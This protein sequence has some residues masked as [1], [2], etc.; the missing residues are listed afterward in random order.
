MIFLFRRLCWGIVAIGL[1]FAAPAQ[2]LTSFPALNTQLLGR[3]SFPDSAETYS[4]LAT[5]AADGREYA[6]IGTR[7]GTAFVE[8]TLPDRPRLVAHLPG[9]RPAEWGGR[10]YQTYHHYA[11]GVAD[12]Q[13]GHSLQIFDLQYLPDSVRLVLDD[14]TQT[15]GAR[16]IQIGNNRLW[17]VNNMRDSAGMRYSSLRVL[18]LA[19]PQTP[20]YLWDAL[21]GWPAG[22]NGTEDA[23]IEADTAYLAMGNYYMLG[24]AEL[25]MPSSRNSIIILERI[26]YSLSGSDACTQVTSDSRTRWLLTL[27]STLAE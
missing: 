27:A 20:T 24:R 2:S 4:G 15:V 7:T 17:L 19:K 6:I 10:S 3:W 16:R 13:S 11:Y 22:Y 5:Y 14:H 9:R 18:S 25:A 8:V 23:L 21:Y 1:S 12:A 26:T